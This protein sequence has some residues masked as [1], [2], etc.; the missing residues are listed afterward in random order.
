MKAVFHKLLFIML[1]NYFLTMI[2]IFLTFFVVVLLLFGLIAG[3]L[4]DWF[5]GGFVG[6]SFL[7]GARGRCRFS[8]IFFW[9]FI[10]AKIRSI[11][12]VAKVWE[13]YRLQYKMLGLG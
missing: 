13:L 11:T 12:S 4:F 3:F 1:F 7:A 2:F 8:F 9:P 5:C 6:L 10:T